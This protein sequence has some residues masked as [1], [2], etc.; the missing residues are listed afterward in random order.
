MNVANHSID[1]YAGQ[2]IR[3]CR[4]DAE[5]QFHALPPALLFCYRNGPDEMSSK[6]IVF[7]ARLLVAISSDA[8]IQHAAYPSPGKVDSRAALSFSSLAKIELLRI[9]FARSTSFSSFRS[10]MHRSAN[11]IARK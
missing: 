5:R 2:L 9:L 7:Y 4:D 11:S 8:R 6:Y 10:V 3:Q 1:L